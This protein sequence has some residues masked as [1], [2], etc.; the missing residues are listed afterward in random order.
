MAKVIKDGKGQIE[1]NRCSFLH[2]GN[3]EAQCVAVGAIENG[4]IVAVDKSAKT[5]KA[6]AKDAEV[7]PKAVYGVNYTSEKI[8]DQFNPGRKNFFVED[9][10]CPRVGILKAG[11]IFTTDADIEGNCGPLKL[12]VVDANADC[13]DGTKAKKYMVL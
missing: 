10:D 4:F 1:L 9:G 8:Y 5:V 6:V 7:D 13:A 3:I 2:D 11:D 12:V